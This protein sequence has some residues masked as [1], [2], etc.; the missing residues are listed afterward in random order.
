MSFGASQSVISKSHIYPLTPLREVTASVRSEYDLSEVMAQVTASVRSESRM[1]PK[2]RPKL[3]ISEVTAGHGR[4]L[5]PLS[6]TVGQCSVGGTSNLRTIPEWT[7]DGVY[8]RVGF[9]DR[10]RV[11]E[12]VDQSACALATARRAQHDGPTLWPSGDEMRRRPKVSRRH[13]G[14]AF[15]EVRRGR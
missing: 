14:R 3:R 8:Y 7:L 11:S 13:R 6:H 4:W 10:D 5:R 2:L 15:A 9:T 1:C 12:S